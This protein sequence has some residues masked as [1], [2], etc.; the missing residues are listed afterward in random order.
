MLNK[1]AAR[2]YAR[3][4]M[5]FSSDNADAIIDLFRKVTESRSSVRYNTFLLHPA[6]EAQEKVKTLIDLSDHEVPG[7]IGRILS[8]LVKR[9]SLDLLPP[10]VDFIVRLREEREGI[11]EADVATTEPLSDDQK[12]ALSDAIAKYTGKSPRMMYRI[13]N[14]LIAGLKVRIGD[15]VFDNSVKR[16]LEIIGD[17]LA[18][19]SR[20]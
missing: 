19:A 15:K 10:I 20:A 9:R 4:I 1:Q 13:E 6:I 16:Q 3:A 5:L 12:T 11:Q 14:D 18:V 2:E 17:L 8:D 7:L